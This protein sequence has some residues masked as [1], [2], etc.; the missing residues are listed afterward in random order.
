MA[1]P[2]RSTSAT[3]RPPNPFS[4]ADEHDACK[5]SNRLTLRDG[6]LQLVGADGKPVDAKNA[7]ASASAS[8]SAFDTAPSGT[9]AQTDAERQR[10]TLRHGQV[11]LV[12]GERGAEEDRTASTTHSNTRTPVACKG[13]VQ[14]S[15]TSDGCTPPPPPYTL[16]AVQA[17]AGADARAE[18]CLAA[19]ARGPSTVATSAR[20]VGRPNWMRA[21]FVCARV[22]NVAA[23]GPC[24]GS[25]AREIERQEAADRTEKHGG[26]APPVARAYALPCFAVLCL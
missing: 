23:L 20:T 13:E 24:C 6:E 4:K 16:E 12:G 10:L 7:A 21:R 5:A 14:G 15:A 11:M 9:A 1:N 2:F 22:V 26:A 19:G 8:A 17:G 25:L 18:Y 3:A